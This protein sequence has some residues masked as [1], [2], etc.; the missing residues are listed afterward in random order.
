MAREGRH[1][2]FHLVRV[3]LEPEWSADCSQFVLW[4]GGR[5]TIWAVEP[6]LAL[7]RQAVIGTKALADPSGHGD[8]TAW[9][10]G[11][12]AGVAVNS[13]FRRE[14]ARWAPWA[15]GESAAPSAIALPG[16]AFPLATSPDGRWLAAGGGEGLVLWDSQVGTWGTQAARKLAV[17]CR[18]ADDQCAARLCQAVGR[19]FN[20]AQLRD[21]FGIANF[22]YFYNTYKRVVDAAAC[23]PERQVPLNLQPVATAT[24][25][26]AAR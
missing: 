7:R 2:S 4:D 22:E 19:H 20:E 15:D 24:R 6:T 8:V 21:L 11:R 9:F 13:E 26:S 18:D 16:A 1:D 17:S 23:P 3:G 25:A 5:P 10:N 12:R 14:G